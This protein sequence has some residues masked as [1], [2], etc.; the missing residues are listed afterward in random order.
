MKLNRKAMAATM[1]ALVFIAII[2]LVAAGIFAY[3]VQYENNTDAKE[4]HDMFFSVELRT[5][6]VYDDPDTQI[7]R[8]C[9]LVAVYILSGK[10][11]I[12]D[13]MNHVLTSV[14]PPFTQYRFVFEYRGDTL[15]IGGAGDVITSQYSSSVA[16]SDGNVMKTTFTLY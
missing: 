13:C 16:V 4:I 3:S 12:F 2:G 9:D 1:D 14:V 15:M 7:V 8:M 10:E 6:D 11:E 5:S